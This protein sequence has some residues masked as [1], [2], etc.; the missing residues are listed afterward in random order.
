MTEYHCMDSCNKCASETITSRVA[1]SDGGHIS[2]CETK[3]TVCGFKDY[4]AYGFFESGQE[5]VSN[6][7]KYSFE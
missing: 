6:C 3:C 4:W 2:E 5:M 7:E 1:Q